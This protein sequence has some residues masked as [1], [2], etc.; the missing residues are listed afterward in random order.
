MLNKIPLLV[1]LIGEEG[2][3]KTHTGLLFPNPILLDCTVQG[4]GLVIAMKACLVDFKARYMHIKDYKDLMSIP[5]GFSTYIFDTS[6]DVVRLF[7]DKWC[8]KH[9]CEKVY[10]PAAYGQVY[11]MIDE[12]IKYIMN[13]PA[14][15][16]MTSV[17]R[18]EYVNDKKTGVRERDGY[19]R[20][21]F[22]SWLRFYIDIR[23]KTRIYKVV[24]NRFVDKTS[25]LFVDEITEFSF[26]KI[27]EITF[28]KANIDKSL[29]V[30]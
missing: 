24:K 30:K 7:S 4:E 9:K 22:E 27:I 19:N 3:G 28:N 8:D 16:V 5:D 2:T 26:D 20:L 6:K 12:I 13:K 15:V 18:D 23:D 1:E 21:S 17:L 10:P 25:D 29:V 14:N 11:D